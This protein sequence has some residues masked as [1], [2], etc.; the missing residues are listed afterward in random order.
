MDLFRAPTVAGLAGLI[1]KEK[2]TASSG[3]VGLRAGSA[4]SPVYCFD[5]TGTHV[6]A[7]RPLALS[8]S[9][10]QAVYGLSL[11]HIFAMKWQEVSFAAIA[12]QQARLIVHQQ[13]T[14][15]Y[16]LLGWSNGGVLAFATAQVLERQGMSVDFLGVLDTQPDLAVYNLEDATPI[17]ELMAYIRRDREEAFSLIPESERDALQQNLTDLSEDAR[18]E[19]AIRWAQER[20]F[21]S[22]EEAEASIGVLKLGYALAKEAALFLNVSQSEPI[23]APIYSWWSSATLARVGSAPI[24]WRKYTNGVVEQY[25]VIGEHSDVIQSIQVHQTLDEI[26]GRLNHRA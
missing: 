2:A 14:G 5:P 11:N 12:E 4:H 25:T 16:R 13:P 21:L 23:D 8:L 10:K 22:M 15:P 24:D 26:L 1:D 7:Y 9:S 19:Y 6:Q 20:D 18:L 17:D 3:I